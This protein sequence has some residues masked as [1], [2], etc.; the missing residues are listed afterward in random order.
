MNWDKIN[1]EQLADAFITLV[2]D[3][4]SPQFG[5]KSK[6][7]F[8]ISLLQTLIS[9]GLINN[10]SSIYEVMSALKVTRGKARNLIYEMKL[11][12]STQES[13]N[14]ELMSLLKN[15]RIEKDG[16]FVILE[17]ENPLLKDF[18]KEQ[19]KKLNF[20][21]DGSFSPDI[22]KMTSEAYITLILS[23]VPSNYQSNTLKFLK[24]KGIEN[25]KDLKVIIAKLLEGIGKKVLGDL[26]GSALNEL[27]GLLSGM[28][29][30]TFE[31]VEIGQI[32]KLFKR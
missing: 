7:D 8:E 6:K 9:L 15:P 3:Y 11:R 28:V 18:I 12:S 32:T 17:V 10:D 22:I 31:N 25:E 20:L 19:M 30:N 29:S 4:C 13:L 5:T 16:K 1:K 26:T 23:N 24:S 21:T 2:D 27:S 14:N